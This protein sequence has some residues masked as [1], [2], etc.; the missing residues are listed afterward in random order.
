MRIG[1]G[2]DGSV[3]L[4]TIHTKLKPLGLLWTMGSLKCGEVRF[5]A[6]PEDHEPRHVHGFVGGTEVVIDLSH[7]GIARLAGRRK[8]V[9]PADTKRSDVRNILALAQE[10]FDELVALWEAMHA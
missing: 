4:D 1:C 5:S 6:Y 2:A 9:K 7:D 8:A 10:H 3:A